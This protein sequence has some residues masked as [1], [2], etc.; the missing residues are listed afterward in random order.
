MD[1]KQLQERLENFGYVR[2]QIEEIMD[3]LSRLSPELVHLRDSLYESG[4]T[5]DFCCHG[6]S[7]SEMIEKH[8]MNYVAAGGL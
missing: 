2:K 4:Q 6:E 3:D 5:S 8:H 7:L 1:E